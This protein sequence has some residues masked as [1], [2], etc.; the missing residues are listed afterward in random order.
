MN[1]R[2]LR[3]RHVVTAFL[4]HQGKILLLQRSERVRTYPGS[5]AAVSGSLEESTPLAQA[6]REIREETSLGEADLCLVATA[7]CLEVADTELATRWLIHPFL[8][9]VIDSPGIRLD[10]EHEKSRWVEAA[11]LARYRTVPAL[12]QALAACLQTESGSKVD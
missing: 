4:R 10:W 6:L 5:W 8:F 7:P 2:S 12:T 1:E 9:E 11:E 3:N